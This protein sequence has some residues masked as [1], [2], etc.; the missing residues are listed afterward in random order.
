MSHYYAR[1]NSGFS[2][3][4]ARLNLTNLYAFPRPGSHCK[5]M[6]IFNV[7][8]PYTFDPQV[9]TSSTMHLVP[10]SGRARDG[11]WPLS[12]LQAGEAIPSSSTRS[13]PYCHFTGPKE[14]RRVS[15]I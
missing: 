7:D 5:S 10:G 13:A 6:L 4:D 15:I 8:P 12:I 11:S 14:V 1:L 3:S 9:P 2:F